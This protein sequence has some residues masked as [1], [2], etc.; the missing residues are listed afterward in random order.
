MTDVLDL[1]LE[2]HGGLENCKSVIG[3]DVRQNLGGYLFEMKQHPVGLP[4]YGTFD[5]FVFRR[6]GASSGAVRAITRRQAA[7]PAS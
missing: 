3:V 7:L 6:A 5:G 4:D 2:A 1:V